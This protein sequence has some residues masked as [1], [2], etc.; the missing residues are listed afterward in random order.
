M[1][2]LVPLRYAANHHALEPEYSCNFTVVVELL[3]DTE[4][5]RVAV[6]VGVGVGVGVVGVG[7]AEAVAEEVVEE[8]ENV[9]AEVAKGTVEG[10]QVWVANVT[11][12]FISKKAVLRPST[13]GTWS[14]R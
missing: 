9:G 3:G 10:L 14:I 5:A 12:N 11:T 8:E 1:V 2:A 13:K 6:G 7:V 4:G